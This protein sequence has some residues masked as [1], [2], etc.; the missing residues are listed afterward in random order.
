LKLNAKT[1]GMLIHIQFES[2]GW[3]AQRGL[4][5]R[6]K[7]A[8][9]I[10]TEQLPQRLQRVAGQAELTLLLTTDARQRRLNHDFRGI[11]RATNVLSFPH[12]KPA[13]LVKIRQANQK[14]YIGDIALAYQYTVKEARLECKLLRNHAIHLAVHG[15]YHLLGYDHLGRSDAAVMERLERRAMAALGLPD[16]YA[17]LN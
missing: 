7:Q 6:L 12:Y 16:P 5:Q 14:I 17:S 10:A 2:Q 9:A 11:D 3:R 1:P 4:P 8:L 13:D 15:F